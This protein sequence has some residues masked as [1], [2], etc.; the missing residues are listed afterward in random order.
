MPGFSEN[1]QSKFNKPDNSGSEKLDSNVSTELS[2]RESENIDTRR[3][4]KEEGAFD[5]EKKVAELKRRHENLKKKYKNRS[6]RWDRTEEGKQYMIEVNQ[7]RIKKA[8]HELPALQ[9]DLEHRRNLLDNAQSRRQEA[10]EKLNKL[11]QRL[12]SAKEKMEDENGSTKELQKEIIK[13]RQKEVDEAHDD[14]EQWHR[15]EDLDQEKIDKLKDKIGKLKEQKKKAQEKIDQLKGIPGVEMQVEDNQDV[16]GQAKR[17][18]ETPVDELRN[19][20]D[21]R[22]LDLIENLNWDR[23]EGGEEKTAPE[24][25]MDAEAHIYKCYQPSEKLKR[26]HKQAIEGIFDGDAD[27]LALKRKW[28]NADTEGKIDVCEH[29]INSMA[30]EYQIGQPI[31]VSINE[32]NPAGEHSEAHFISTSGG[33]EFGYVNVSPKNLDLPLE[34]AVRLIAHEMSHGYQKWLE[35]LTEEDREGV[36][37][38]ANDVDWFKSSSRIGAGR[39]LGYSFKSSHDRYLSLPKEQDAYAMQEIAESEAE[40]RIASAE[41]EIMESEGLPAVDKI[42][43]NARFARWAKKMLKNEE[44]ETGE[45][46]VAKAEKAL[47]DSGAQKARSLFADLSAEGVNDF[48]QTTKEQRQRA[49]EA[50]GYKL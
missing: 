13:E 3:A 1:A 5:T 29:I 35:E 12:E 44:I 36:I 49:E 33:D 37:G 42:I 28:K 10:Q 7:F 2:K 32:A 48:I 23:R 50:L 41:N 24:V 9:E 4:E 30:S 17:V 31:N 34:T 46:L 15:K 40:N 38:D 16:I 8:S 14:V 20:P 6:E 21:R 39:D 43:K 22:L 11:E 19:M 25:V 27:V 45:D 18:L 26:S 47:T